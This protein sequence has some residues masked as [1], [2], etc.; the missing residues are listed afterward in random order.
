MRGFVALVQIGLTA[1]RSIVERHGGRI[2]VESE[3]GHGSI[4]HFTVP[5]QPTETK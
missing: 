3:K 4:F 5:D 1:C 2:W